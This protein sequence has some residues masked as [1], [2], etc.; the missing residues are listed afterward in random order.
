MPGSGLRY[1]PGT[2][3]NTDPHGAPPGVT[4]VPVGREDDPEPMAPLAP[5]LPIAGN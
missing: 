2:L 5:E 1:V 4:G 3:I